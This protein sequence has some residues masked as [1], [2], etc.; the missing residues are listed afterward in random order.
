MDFDDAGKLIER[1]EMIFGFRENDFVDMNGR[2]ARVMGVVE[3]RELALDVGST[4]EYRSSPDG[5]NLLIRS[6]FDF[7]VGQ[8]VKAMS[9]AAP[10]NGEQGYILAIEPTT[11][12]VLVQFDKYVKNVSET[13]WMACPFANGPS[14]VW[15]NPSMA[16]HKLVKI[17]QNG[18]K[19]ITGASV[20]ERISY[21]NVEGTDDVRPMPEWF[22][23]FLHQAKAGLSHCF[24][25]WGNI[26][27]WQKRLNGQYQTLNAFLTDTF[28]EHDFVMYYSISTGLRFATDKMESDFKDRYLKPK[29]LA[30][31]PGIGA[32]PQEVAMFKAM[33]ERFSTMSVNEILK[34][35]SPD[36][37][38][39]AVEMALIDNKKFNDKA[40]PSSVI[41]VEYAHHVFPKDEMQGNT[42]YIQRV[43]SE[44][45]QRWAADIRIRTRMNVIAMI[46]PDF[47]GVDT[48]LRTSP[49]VHAIQ[50]K[51]PDEKARAERWNYWLSSGGVIVEPGMEASKL[52]RVSTGFSLRDIDGLYRLAAT[53]QKPLTYGALKARKAAIYKERFGERINVIDPEYGFDYFGGREE[54][55]EYLREVSYNMETGMFRRVPMG[56]L[57]SGQ[58][59][60]GK[61]FLFQCWAHECGFNFVSFENPRAMFVGQAEEIMDKMLYA[62]DELCPVI[63]VED[64]ADQSESSRDAPDCDAGVSSRLRQ[65]KFIFCSDPKRR[66][67][68]VWVRISNRDDLLD[69]AYKR[70]GRSD[71]VIPFVFQTEAEMQDIF[72]VMFKRYQI[73]TTVKDFAPFAHEVENKIYCVG[74]DIEWMVLEADQLAGRMQRQAVTEEDLVQAIDSWELKNNAVE[75]DRQA[76]AA[77]KGSSKRLRPKGWEARLKQINERLAKAGSRWSDGHE[78][79]PTMPPSGIGDGIASGATR[80]ALRDQRIG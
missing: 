3:K 42:P 10:F 43:I 27:D 31:K 49:G 72:R 11:E 36:I 26:N 8:V 57:A 66:G 79:N 61:T 15:L 34:G 58:P 56:I 71:Q 55:K 30:K 39:P 37:I 32:D 77:L 40:A 63:V 17:S 12:M 64:E 78:P 16:A 47:F 14:R 80:R 28:K 54:V 73:S 41:M 19:A 62:V 52:G 1:K 44:T 25:F 76:K 18:H 23:E 46:T 9:A 67:K 2:K 20:G 38:F 29:A 45:M 21:P 50:I 33:Q 51:V 4:V 74:A 75:I 5:L 60:T 22:Q 48:D 35:S 68:V 53:K 59:G 24:M 6:G 69:S 7:A 65:K 13:T 70:K